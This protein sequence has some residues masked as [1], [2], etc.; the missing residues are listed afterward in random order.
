[1]KNYIFKWSQFQ[2]VIRENLNKLRFDSDFCDITLACEDGQQVEAHKLVLSMASPFFENLLKRNQ[3]QTHP[4]VYMRGV[5]SLD[6][7]AL[8]DFFYL[9][10]ATVPQENL[11]SFLSIAEEL[12]VVGLSDD[13]G[14][15]KGGTGPSG[16][17]EFSGGG[18]DVGTR[19]VDLGDCGE[20]VEK[21]EVRVKTGSEK[22]EAAG[23]QND[24][25]AKVVNTEFELMSSRAKNWTDGDDQIFLEKAATSRQIGEKED[26]LIEEKINSMMTPSNKKI[27]NKLAHTCKVCGKEAR[28]S[29][30]KEHIRRHHMLSK[31][32]DLLTCRI[33]EAICSHDRMESHIL[34][35]HKN[36]TKNLFS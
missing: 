27:S 6:L 32:K 35:V 30:M 29:H 24:A 21:E 19:L 16:D 20:R 2:K 7:S 3:Q 4:M 8:L 10:Q 26:S 18:G 9:G 13:G 25:G 34:F 17:V 28:I 15:G 5:K 1:M 14:L 36:L 11:D 31:N 22:M 33:C 23:A 12:Q